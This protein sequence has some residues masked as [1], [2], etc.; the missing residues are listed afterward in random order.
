MKRRKFSAEFKSKITL[1]SIRGLKTLNE[2]SS[3]YQV[4]PNQI[5]NCLEEVSLREKTIIIPDTAD[6]QRRKE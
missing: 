3:E 2:I 5:S 4:H 1:E 6:I